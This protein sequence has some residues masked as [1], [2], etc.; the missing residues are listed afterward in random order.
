MRIG[1]VDFK[2]NEAAIYVD[3]QWEDRFLF[4]E[5]SSVGQIMRLRIEKALEGLRGFLLTGEN[6]KY[7]LRE[8]DCITAHCAQDVVIVEIIKEGYDGKLALASERFRLCISEEEEEEYQRLLHFDPV[9]KVLGRSFHPLTKWMAQY[10]Q[11]PLVTNDR[12]KLRAFI[13]EDCDI[14]EEDLDIDRDTRFAKERRIW[15]SDDISDGYAQIIIEKT[16]AAIVIDVNQGV[17]KLRVPREEQVRRVNDASIPL[18]VKAMALQQ[19][20]GILL[21]D[22][23]RMSKK[24]GK[25]Y[26][27][28]LTREF[29]QRNLPARVLGF[30]RSGLVEVL[31][32]R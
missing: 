18:I 4:K 19:D 21:I 27:E 26:L 6:E 31:L 17:R 2:R 7:L 9:P 14:Q 13:G 20:K 23:I 16:A 12:K 10:R 8:K 5:E 1:F 25:K 28:N 22:A 3:G 11:T 29:R 15:L 30:S 24:D 32:Y